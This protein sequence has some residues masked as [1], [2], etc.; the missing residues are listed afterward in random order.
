MMRRGPLADYPIDTVLRSA[1]RERLS[2]S[3][4]TEG[5]DVDGTIYLASGQVFAAEL[6]GTLP[7]V[8]L[9]GEHGG[10]D[11]TGRHIVSALAVLGKATVGWFRHDPFGA[12]DRETRWRFDV[13]DLLK[14]TEEPRK[15][16]RWFGRWAMCPVEVTPP[17]D[18]TVPIGLDAWRVIA[19]LSRPGN[20]LQVNDSLGWS[21]NRLAAALATL[22]AAGILGGSLTPVEEEVAVPAASSEWSGAVTTT[23]KPLTALSRPLVSESPGVGARDTAAP[24]NPPPAARAEIAVA[25]P[26]VASSAP[27][28]PPVAARPAAAGDG[29]PAQSGARRHALK[30]LIDSLRQ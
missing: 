1:A 30:R 26:A 19:A 16:L 22:E 6:A 15:G 12:V 3:I 2:G 5:S 29:G 17:P 13:E 4:V 23:A 9:H 27:T 10:R 24:T 14:A 20:V 21:P 28:R 8:V 7:D 25:A 18:P 11:Q